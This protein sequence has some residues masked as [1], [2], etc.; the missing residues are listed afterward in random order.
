MFCVLSVTKEKRVRQHTVQTKLISGAQM[1]LLCTETTPRRSSQVGKHRLLF[2]NYSNDFP[3]TRFS[4]GNIPYPVYTSAGQYFLLTSA[5]YFRPGVQT[6]LRC[7][8]NLRNFILRMLD[9]S[10][11]YHVVGMS[12]GPF[13]QRPWHVAPCSDVYCPFSSFSKRSGLIFVKGKKR[14]VKL[15]RVLRVHNFLYD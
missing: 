2:I 6:R 13:M 4:F 15:V 5:F 1:S 14:G 12:R 8:S 10:F 3:D 7:S 9:S 11:A